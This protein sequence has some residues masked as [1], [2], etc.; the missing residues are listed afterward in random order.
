MN[1]QRNSP[2][3]PKNG[4]PLKQG[5]QGAPA[6]GR[7]WLSPFLRNDPRPEW[8][9]FLLSDDIS[10]QY[11]L[12]LECLVVTFSFFNEASCKPTFI[13]GYAAAPLTDLPASLACPNLQTSSMCTSADFKEQGRQLLVHSPE[14]SPSQ[15]ET[16]L[17]GCPPGL[18]W[19]KMPV[20]LAGQWSQSLWLFKEKRPHPL[21]QA[22]VSWQTYLLGGKSS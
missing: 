8:P 14:A 5:S 20:S 17:N 12:A 13:L 6:P 4:N 19:T 10:S 18:K 16:R 15:G 11:S 2:F 22:T 7:S 21:L 1:R 3:F 9:S